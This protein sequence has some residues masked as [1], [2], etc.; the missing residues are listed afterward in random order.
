MKF[1]ETLPSGQ[2]IDAAWWDTTKG[3]ALVVALIAVGGIALAVALTAVGI[4]LAELL[5]LVYVE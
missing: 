2:V 3:T 5:W 1:K 4:G